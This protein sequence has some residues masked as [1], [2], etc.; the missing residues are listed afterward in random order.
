MR[1]RCCLL[2]LLLAALVDELPLVVGGTFRSPFEL[3]TVAP[4]CAA[5]GR[6]WSWAVGRR[7]HGTQLSTGSLSPPTFSV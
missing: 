1:S 5:P 2:M 3:V 6:P 4:Q 7:W